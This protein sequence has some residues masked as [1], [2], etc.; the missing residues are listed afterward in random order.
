VCSAK[1][2]YVRTAV[3]F[4]NTEEDIDRFLDHLDGK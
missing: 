3:H 2:A 1:D 4:Y